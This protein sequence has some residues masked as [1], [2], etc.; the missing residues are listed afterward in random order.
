[1]SSKL[2]VIGLGD[3]RKQDKGLTI[4]LLD[5]LK[6]IFSETLDILFIEGGFDG[7]DL[8]ETLEDIDAE[9]IV[10]LDTM[11][12]IVKPGELDYLIIKPREAKSLK[13]LLMVTIGILSDDWGKK[14]SNSLCEK[15][16]DILDK[17]SNII[18]NLLN[19]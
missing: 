11:R 2:A 17:V 4:Y 6:N 5:K 3:V 18:N 13:E 10:V 15:F 12:E 7:E 8:F 16:Y 19:K 9:K 14:L 1:M